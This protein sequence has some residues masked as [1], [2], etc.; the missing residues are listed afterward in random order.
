V[1]EQT[2]CPGLDLRGFHRPDESLADDAMSA[3]EH[4]PGPDG[5]QRQPDTRKGAVK[6]AQLA[7]MTA[8]KA[9]DPPSRDADPQEPVRIPLR[10]IEEQP[11]EQAAGAPPGPE[12]QPGTSILRSLSAQLPGRAQRDVDPHAASVLALRAVASASSR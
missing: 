10:V 8:G 6:T 12:R 1:N 3:T 9:G 2:P 7:F 4:K 5:A 11:V